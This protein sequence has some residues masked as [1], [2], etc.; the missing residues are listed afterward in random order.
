MLNWSLHQVVRRPTLL[1]EQPRHFR[2][3]R[4]SLIL[5]IFV[6]WSCWIVSWISH[7]VCQFVVIKVWKLSELHHLTNTRTSMEHTGLRRGSGSV[8]WAADTHSQLCCIISPVWPFISLMTNW[9]TS[10]VWLMTQFKQDHYVILKCAR[11]E[12]LHS[13]DP[14]TEP[15]AVFR[16]LVHRVSLE[17]FLWRLKLSLMKKIFWW[18]VIIMRKGGNYEIKCHHQTHILIF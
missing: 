5:K 18:L 2:F 14:G 9:Q 3:P 6:Y 1:Y 12:A 13:T 16:T 7:D 15:A 10:Y 17:F 4:W 11:A 8:L